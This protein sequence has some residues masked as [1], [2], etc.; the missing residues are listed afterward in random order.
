MTRLPLLMLFVAATA[1][2]NVWE[3]ALTKGK[4]DPAQ[5]KYESELRKGDEHALLA[6][7]HQTTTKEVRNQIQAAIAA[8]KAAAA[9]KPKEGEPWFRLGSLINSFFLEGCERNRPQLQRTLSRVCSAG[10]DSKRAEEAI[11]Y[12]NQFEARAPDDPR[13]GVELRGGT[14]QILFDRAILHTKLGTRP[15]LEAAARDYEK[16]LE[17]GDRAQD[18]FE[19]TLGNLAETYMM[20]GRMDESLDLYREVLRNAADTSTY[21]GYA[22]ALDRDEHTTQALEII[23]S[24]GRNQREQFRDSVERGFTFFV[25]E[26]E[27]YYYFALADEAFGDEEQAIANWRAFIASKAHPQFQPRAKAHLDKLMSHRKRRSAPIQPPWQ[28]IFR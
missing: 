13:L 19:Q 21:Y 27:K 7:T 3:S 20:L 12:W 15:H 25:P 14:T 5:E 24:Q 26:G 9:A 18:N 23:K 16:I 22:V 28:E 11:E 4:P 17:R 1:H 10:F 8:Y 6:N 2:A